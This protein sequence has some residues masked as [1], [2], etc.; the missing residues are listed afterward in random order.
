MRVRM[1]ALDLYYVARKRVFKHTIFMRMTFDLSLSL[2]LTFFRSILPV[3][4]HDSCASVSGTINIDEITYTCRAY[5]H[6]YA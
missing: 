4:V 1:Y 3:S 6:K 5:A 2:C